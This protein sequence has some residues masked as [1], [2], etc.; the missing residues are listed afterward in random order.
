[1]KIRFTEEHQSSRDGINIVI[2]KKD[3]VIDV[4]AEKARMYI[5]RG[6][7]CAHV[8]ENRE[9]KVVKAEEPKLAK[10]QRKKG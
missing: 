4:S 10:P 5:E 7:A 9:T 1:M 2:F 3:E 6:V 8:I